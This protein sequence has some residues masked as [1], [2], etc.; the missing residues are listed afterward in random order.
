M[1]VLALG[2]RKKKERR[3]V[4]LDLKKTSNL[5]MVGEWQPEIMVK[6]L[7]HGSLRVQVSVERAT[8]RFLPVD[9]SMH[10]CC[11][12]AFFYILLIWQ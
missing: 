5:K 11:W 10:G 4:Y 6:S 7:F 1:V 3:T 8:G 2:R 12:K 9:P